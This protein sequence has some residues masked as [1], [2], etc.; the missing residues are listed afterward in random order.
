[1]TLR[2]LIS[3]IVIA[4]LFGLAGTY[5]SNA[6]AAFFGTD[7]SD[8]WWVPA[9]SGWG[10]QVVQQANL[11]FATMFVYD[12]AGSPTWYIATLDYVGLD[13]NGKNVWTG[14][15]YA[16][17]GPWLGTVPFDPKT[18]AGS[19]VGSMTFTPQFIE[20]A[21]LTYSINGVTVNKA[22]TRQVLVYEDFNGAFLGIYDEQAT[23]V[24]CPADAS[25]TGAPSFITIAQANTAM[26]INMLTGNPI[27]VSCSYPGTY[28]QAGH[29]GRLDGNYTCSNGDFGT[30]SFNEMEQSSYTVRLRFSFASQAF[31]CS[32]SGHLAGLQQQSAAIFAK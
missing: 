4:L 20:T 29:F 22:I 5:V 10:I 31:V 32:G 24:G 14:T 7:H 21:N 30:F 2:R 1:M 23:G 13:S 12:Q 18:V 19:A 11:L 8:L 6:K 15:V 28:R 17:T 9:E 27:L 25:T 16:T 3:A 26:T